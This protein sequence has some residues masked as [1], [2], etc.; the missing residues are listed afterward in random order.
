MRDL[1]AYLE[2]RSR[3]LTLYDYTGPDERLRELSQWLGGHGIDVRT[4]NTTDA[5]LDDVAVLH[6]DGTVLGACVADDLLSRLAFEGAIED[7]EAPPVPESVASLPSDVT[8]QPARTVE[9]M[10]RVS[11]EYERRALREGAGELHA[12]FQRLS[13]LAGSTRTME[14]Y[15]ALANEGVDVRVY[16]YPDATLHDVPFTV[17]ADDDREVARYWFLLY[18]GNGNPRR[19]A[20]LVSEERPT[21]GDRLGSPA[22][23][24]RTE[25]PA[26]T[27]D[28]FFTT[29]PNTVDE[30]FELARDAHGDLLAPPG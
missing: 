16:G 23:D 25:R 28:S 6:R 4:A 30:L 14:V 22:P 15:R 29:D 13:A 11:R 1:L 20:A 18:D 2:R 27:Y 10:V 3:T 12:G 7:G 5:T 26:G 9:E 8:V 24:A 17:V 19:K 21:D